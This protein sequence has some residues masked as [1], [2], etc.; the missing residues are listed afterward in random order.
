MILLALQTPVLPGLCAGGS[1][2]TM[3]RLKRGAWAKVLFSTLVL[4]PFGQGV[5][6]LRL[7]HEISK[8]EL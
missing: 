2:L 1:V 8:Y 4:F 3:S 6:C 5:D 7:E